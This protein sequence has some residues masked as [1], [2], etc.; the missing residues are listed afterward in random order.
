[1][2]S[3]GN[4]SWYEYHRQM[5]AE[6]SRFIEWGLQ[7]PEEVTWIPAK[8]AEGGGFPSRVSEWYWGTV[9]SDRIDGTVRRWRDLLRHRPG[10]ISR[11]E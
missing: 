10:A 4:E 7:H 6:T 1:M 3:A 11:R 8:P 9:L 5:L 2:T